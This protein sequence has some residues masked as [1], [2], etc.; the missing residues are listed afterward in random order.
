L[1]VVAAAARLVLE[2]L[3]LVQMEAMAAQ[4]QQTALLDH[5]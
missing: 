2:E 5:L 1:L 4:V 3:D